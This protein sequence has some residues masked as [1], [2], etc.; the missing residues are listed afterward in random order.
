M[1]LVN[2]NLVMPLA[3]VVRSR[4]AVLSLHT[5][6]FDQEG[7]CVSGP[8][9]SGV[10]GAWLN[11]PLL[12]EAI[13]AAVDRWLAQPSAP[14]PVAIFEECWVIPL[15]EPAARRR[16][17]I[18]AALALGPT[19]LASEDFHRVC[20]SAKLDTR[21]AAT[22]LARAA[23]HSESSARALAHTLQ[24]SV[25]DLVA[26]A[27]GDETANSTGRQLTEL[28]EEFDLLYRLGRSMNELQHPEKFVRLAC[29]ELARTVPFNW[30]A[31]RFVNDAA[32]ARSMAG[33][34]FT[35]EHARVPV[36]DIA[37]VLDPLITRAVPTVQTI[38]EASDAL[39][40]VGQESQ[41]LLYPI[42]RAGQVVGGLAAGDKHGDDPMISNADIKLFEA[43]AGYVGT[44][45]DN[46]FMYDDQQ[47]LF[48]GTVEALTASIDAK[49]PYTC[50]HSERVAHLAARL[51]AAHGLDDEQVERIRVAG[52][53]HDIGKIGVPEAVLCKAG[54]LTDE[55][56]GLIKEHP[57]I[58]FDI[59][60][61]IPLLGDVL[62]GVL[63]HHERFDGRGYPR[64]LMGEDIPL[65]ARIIGLADS[66]DAMSSTRTYRSALPRER[67]LGEIRAHA[68]TQFDPRLAQD[69]LTLDLARYDEL[70]IQH[71]TASASG[72]LRVRRRT[73][74]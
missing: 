36:T 34:T 5:W 25:D 67:V 30:L 71:Q 42:I 4:C 15:V 43:A 40:L 23:T 3:E 60:K 52:L 21:A 11:A 58:G 68:G 13:R 10:A 31:I 74:A 6:R 16:R 51:A 14:E 39:A 46:A 50:G 38:V 53:V 56:F 64:G 49:D 47:L 8:V 27:R 22:A 33:R 28:Y 20:H 35:A 62:P 69:F 48:L 45:L 44:L 72:G 12:R 37:A 24:W 2:E 61:D 26:A 59:L 9:P 19:H 1:T 29:N 66:F 70:V 18:I 73:A 55:E 7:R 57:Q 41:I 17:F 54:K 63:H 32:S 65:I